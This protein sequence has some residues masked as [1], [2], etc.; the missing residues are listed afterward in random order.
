[1]PQMSNQCVLR[2][3]SLAIECRQNP[4]AGKDE[5]IV[6]PRAFGQN[7]SSSALRCKPIRDAL[8]PGM[9]GGSCL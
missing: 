7:P 9:C 1:M 2:A 3:V 5:P 6:S 4:R 8:E